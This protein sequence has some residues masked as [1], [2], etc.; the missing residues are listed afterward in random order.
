ME[1]L[2]NLREQINEIDDQLVSLYL[3]RMEIVG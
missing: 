3:K 1:N 2:E